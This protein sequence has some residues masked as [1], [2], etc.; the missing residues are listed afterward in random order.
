MLLF[1]VAPSVVE[2]L[3]TDPKHKKGRLNLT[4]KILIRMLHAL[5]SG[6]SYS[7]AGYEFSAKDSTIS[8]Q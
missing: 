1:Q 4:K 7:P 8:I 2:E 3:S 5:H 6:N